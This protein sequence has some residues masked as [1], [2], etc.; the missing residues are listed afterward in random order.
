VELPTWLRR[1]SVSSF[2]LVEK[3]DPALDG[4]PGSGYIS[5]DIELL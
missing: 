2:P 4:S 3:D 1:R 5:I